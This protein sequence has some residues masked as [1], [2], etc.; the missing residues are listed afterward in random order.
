MNDG[1]NRTPP[2]RPPI[3]LG[4]SSAIDR[5]KNP[6]QAAHPGVD[7]DAPRARTEES[8]HEELM[9]TVATA[10]LIVRGDVPQ[11]VR[12]ALAAFA[13]LGDLNGAEVLCDILERRQ[14][15]MFAW[16]KDLSLRQALE[17]AAS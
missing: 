15:D 12:D 14:Q 5:N 9:L 6:E 8:F 1:I 16:P 2:I 11:E 13:P 17:A 4:R 3:D 7:A 10:R